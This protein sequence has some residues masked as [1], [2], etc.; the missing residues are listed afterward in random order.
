MNQQFL[1]DSLK[2][3]GR[4]RNLRVERAMRCV[5]RQHFVP[6]VER[7]YINTP[8]SI[9][10]HV[11]ISAPYVH[12]LMLE[13][14]TPFIRPGSTVLDVG[15]GSGYIT[16]CL[17]HLLMHSASEEDDQN[18]SP[19]P[20]MRGCVHAID[21]VK[22][23]IDRSKVSLAADPCTTALMQCIQFHVG[24]GRK[25]LPKVAPFDAIH[26]GAAAKAPPPALLQQLRPGGCLVMP[27][28]NEVTQVTAFVKDPLTF[29]IFERVITDAP[30]VPL[31]SL[32]KQLANN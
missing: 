1:I 29:E 8:Q 23:L 24:D 14:L 11:T 9:G 6:K 20:P 26:V 21:H 3:S 31:T 5:D 30:F 7:A 15:S 27:I 28:V 16:A 2:F 4:I 12:A 13:A 32:T 18:S 25:G 17:A 22:D 10:F 19:S